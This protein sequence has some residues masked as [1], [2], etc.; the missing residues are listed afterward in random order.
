M[1]MMALVPQYDSRECWPGACI[2]Q[3]TLTLLFSCQNVHKR[4]PSGT[5][6]LSK[7]M[8]GCFQDLNQK[9][10]HGAWNKPAHPHLVHILLSCC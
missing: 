5:A 7:G 9:Y 3:G 6:V 8:G 10:N 1:V 4:P 2:V